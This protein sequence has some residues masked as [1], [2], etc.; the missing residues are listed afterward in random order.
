MLNYLCG[1]VGDGAS[2]IQSKVKG[3]NGRMKEIN[4]SFV[5]IW[6]ICH[7]CNLFTKPLRLINETINEIFEFCKLLCAFFRSSPKRWTIISLLSKSLNDDHHLKSFPAHSATRWRYNLDQ[8]NA[9]YCN[10]ET[11]LVLF[12]VL[13]K[14]KQ[15]G[16]ET[17]LVKLLHISK[18]EV[19]VEVITKIEY[20]MKRLMDYDFMML[21]CTTHDIL[22]FINSKTTIFHKKGMDRSIA[23]KNLKSLKKGL[24]NLAVL[25]DF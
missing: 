21:L 24:D 25:L 13:L 9:V 23:F 5:L 6:C 4:P 19:S 17:E 8:L 7:K 14:F 2:N 18:N 15:N 1:G 22:D 11:L 16:E 10:Y 3:F 12:R 20:F